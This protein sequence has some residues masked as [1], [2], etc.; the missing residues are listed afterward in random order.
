MSYP[1]TKN[2]FILS[3]LWVFDAFKCLDDSY[4]N[5]QSK[6]SAAGEVEQML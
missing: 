3:I 2:P 5:V 6:M 1:F 4:K